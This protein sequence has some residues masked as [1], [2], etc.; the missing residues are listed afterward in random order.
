M[1]EYADVQLQVPF[2]LRVP[3]NMQLV[4][5]MGMDVDG[6]SWIPREMLVYDDQQIVFRA[7]QKEK[8]IERTRVVPRI[9]SLRIVGL[10]NR[11]SFRWQ[12][13][14]VPQYR[15]C[16]WINWIKT[17]EDA[18]L[19]VV[20]HMNKYCGFEVVKPDEAKQKGV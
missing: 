3:V 11:Q 8:Y 4:C 1:I 7:M 2:D 16:H 6:Q 15:W 17:L 12:G 20:A 10:T 13:G 14:S 19:C 5:T 18:A 9:L